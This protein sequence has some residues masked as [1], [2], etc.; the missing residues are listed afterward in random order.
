DHAREYDGDTSRVVLMG[1]SAGAHL[2]ILAAYRHPAVRV[3]GVVSYYGPADLIDAYRNPPRPDPL[4]IR[5]V[6]QFF[7]GGTPD[8]MPR[9]YAAASP[10]TYVTRPLPPTLLVYG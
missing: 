10:V 8:S 1:R 3:R 4:H 9:D 2:A 6:E 5:T 7:I